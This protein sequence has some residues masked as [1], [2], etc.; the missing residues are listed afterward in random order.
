LTAALQLV[1]V[2]QPPAAPTASERFAAFDAENPHV[3]QAF[4]RFAL[5][6]VR[7]GRQRIGAKA[8]WERMRWWST[9]E[10]NDPEFKLNNNWTAHLAR[11]WQR[12]HPEHADLFATREGCR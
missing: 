10:S 12:L 2:E 5:E 9:V 7:A 1:L 11:K 4:E 3:W 8:L 6:A